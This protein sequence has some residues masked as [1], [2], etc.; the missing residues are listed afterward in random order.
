[1]RRR[2]SHLV[3]LVMLLCS[4]Q[5]SENF[6]LQLADSAVT[7]RAIGASQRRVAALAARPIV[8]REAIASRLSETTSL[9][10]A[11]RTAHRTV[12]IMRR[13]ARAA[14]AVN[15]HTSLLRA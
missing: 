1:M 7:R 9:N 2:S 6:A 3:F 15:N 12:W 13:P 5:V 10:P 11:A 4:V 8:A 14:A